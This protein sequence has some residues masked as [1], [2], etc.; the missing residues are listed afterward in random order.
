MKR[1]ASR[2][3]LRPFIAPLR[4]RRLLLLLLLLFLFSSVL[5]DI[6]GR[7]KVRLLRLSHLKMISKLTI[8]GA[9]DAQVDEGVRHNA[10]GELGEVGVG[11]GND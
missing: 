11:V 8:I 4:F 10:D 7:V 9:S 1:I 2:Y 3:S 6:V 5:I